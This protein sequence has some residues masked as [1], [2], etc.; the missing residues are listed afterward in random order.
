[1]TDGADVS[2]VNIIQNDGTN[3]F[4]W[5]DIKVM[6]N[7]TEVFNEYVEGNICN[8]VWNKLYRS[9]LVKKVPFPE[10]HQHVEDAQ[11]TLGLWKKLTGWYV[12]PRGIIIILFIRE[13]LPIETV[14]IRNGKRD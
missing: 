3:E 13:A 4:L 7:N 8:R 11:W 5:R 10:D 2:M 12:S 14:G 1:M 6:G 9:E